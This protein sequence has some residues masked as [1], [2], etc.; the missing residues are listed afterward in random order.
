MATDNSGNNSIGS[1]N[2]VVNDTQKPSIVELPVDIIVDNDSGSCG[3][4]V[5]WI[6]PSSDDNCP[7][8][9][10]SQ[11]EGFANGSLFPIG[12]TSIS[13]TA[14]DANGNSVM[15]SF[16]VI[17]NDTEDPSILDL[18]EDITTSNNIN[19]CGAIVS[20]IEPTSLDN[21]SGSSIDQTSG[22]ENGSLFPM[23]SS[24]VSYTATDAS[25]NSHEESFT[26]TVNDNEDPT[27]VGLP[28]D[29]ILANDAGVCGAVASWTEPTSSDNCPGNTIN[30]TSGLVSGSLFPLGISTISYEASDAYGNTF[31]ASFTVT[32]NDTEAP[33]ISAVNDFEVNPDSGCD[34]IIPD[35]TALASAADNCGVQ[36]IQQAPPPG[37]LVSGHGNTQLITLTAN[38]VNGNSSSTTFTIT[39]LGTEIY[40]ADADQDGYGDDGNSILDCSQPAGYVSNNLDC[41]DANPFVYPGAEEICD[42]IDNNCD[43]LIDDADP[44]IVGQ[45]IWYQDFDGDNYGNEAVSFI[46]CDQPGGYV[47]DHTDC[48]DNNFNVNPG[49][50]EI[51]ANGV[52]DDCNPATLDG[53]D[54]DGDG[55]VND[56]DPD[57]D[58]D[59]CLD[60]NDPNPFVA[61]IDE[62]GDGIVADCDVV[63][64]MLQ[65]IAMAMEFVTISI[66]VLVIIRSTLTSMGSDACDV[67]PLDN[68]DDS[69]GD[70]ICDL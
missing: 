56:L 8:S 24:T 41:D 30:Q 33:S 29:I 20:W 61:S 2:V 69:D 32:V 15:G 64:M 50:V 5:S 38:D 52:D 57:D 23:G 37:T 49:V 35:Y 42:G 13:Y 1:F 62:D 47:Q 58:N 40:Y 11:T 14:I 18:P 27:I 26:V 55:I 3:A 6:E 28:N 34:F 67:C 48:D 54:N 59:G 66:P 65:E 70:G 17:V 7:G 19:S 36:S 31:E 44:L 39:L 4:I 22:P 43:G 60:I 51:P 16:N 12:S 46:S 45:I 68:P 53:D 9:S 25:G 21:C 63:A 10:I